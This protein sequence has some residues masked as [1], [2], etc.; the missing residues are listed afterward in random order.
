MPTF[1]LSP[2]FYWRAGAYVTTANEVTCHQ[3]GGVHGLLGN[4]ACVID[5][6]VP[7]AAMTR[8]SLLSTRTGSPTVSRYARRLWIIR[9][10][11]T[12]MSAT[13]ASGAR[14]LGPKIGHNDKAVDLTP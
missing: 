13:S 4:V 3:L 14:R 9:G 1:Q 12:G 11:L 8:R 6:L 5:T 2:F 10:I 7:F